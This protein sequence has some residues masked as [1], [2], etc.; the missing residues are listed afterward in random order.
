M[1]FRL[2]PRSGKAQ[3]DFFT[4]RPRRATDRDR[5][6]EELLG[7]RIVSSPHSRARPIDRLLFPL[8]YKILL[9]SIPPATLLL[10]PRLANWKALISANIPLCLLLR[11]GFTYSEKHNQCSVSSF[12]L[13]NFLPPPRN[14]RRLIPGKRG[15]GPVGREIRLFVAISL[16]PSAN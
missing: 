2:P 7:I 12:L 13:L 1:A 9:L 6:N 8:L 15:R 11:G 4:D 5:G 10:L 14:E 3:R 16:D